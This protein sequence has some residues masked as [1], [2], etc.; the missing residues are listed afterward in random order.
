MKRLANIILL[1]LLAGLVVYARAVSYSVSLGGEEISRGSNDSIHIVTSAE[2]DLPGGCTIK[3]E[4]NGNNIT[5]GSWELVVVGVAAN[6]SA[7]ERGTVKGSVASGS[8]SFSEEGKVA[9]VDAQLIISSGTG[10]YSGASGG[11]S[12]GGSVGAQRTPP[13]RGNLSLNF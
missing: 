5:G 10:T 9:S 8:L 12:L 13:F 3:I 7:E 2:G 6:G 11:G 1:G 4:H